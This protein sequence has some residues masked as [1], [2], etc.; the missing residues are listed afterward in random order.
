MAR[1]TKKGIDYFSFDVDFFEDEKIEPISGEFGLKGEMIVIRLLCAV[2]RN[3]YFAVWNEQLKMTLANRCKVS[4]ELI[5]QVIDRLVKWG[6]FDEHLFISAKILTSKGI[7]RRFKEATRKRKYKYEELE[8]WLVFDENGVSSANNSP[9]KEFLPPITTQSKVK[10]SIDI[11]SG[12][13]YVPSPEILNSENNN[14]VD[15]KKLVERFNEITGKK[16]NT[17]M[18]AA[19]NNILQ[20]L[21]LGFT[22]EDLVKAFVKASK[23]P[24]LKKNPTLLSLIHITDLNNFERYAN[25]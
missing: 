19:R 22:K 13:S 5:Q 25:D 23:D 24:Y 11:E 4:F 10:E 16:Y 14:T 18:P 17:I 21:R 2:Y 12:Y 8:F 6:F 9:Q 1:P 3:G 20:I 15:W 7:Q